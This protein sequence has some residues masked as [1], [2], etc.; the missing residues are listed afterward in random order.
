MATLDQLF[1]D[2]I[3]AVGKTN[4]QEVFTFGCEECTFFLIAESEEGMGRSGNV[5]PIKK[6][7]MEGFLKENRIASQ[8]DQ[9]R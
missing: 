2:L 7:H 5:F 4:A 3:S 9:H 1:S 8:G 6:K